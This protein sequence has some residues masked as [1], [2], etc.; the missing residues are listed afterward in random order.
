[1]NLP[2][3]RDAECCA[4]CSYGFDMGVCEVALECEHPEAER[5]GKYCPSVEYYGICDWYE[6]RVDKEV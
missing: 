1:M 6:K 2:N 3:Y 4:T 5:Q